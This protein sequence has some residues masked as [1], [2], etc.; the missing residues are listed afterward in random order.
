MTECYNKLGL[1]CSIDVLN[2]FYSNKTDKNIYYDNKTKDIKDEDRF[3]FI[4]NE[5]INYI[6]NIDNPS[7][8]YKFCSVDNENNNYFYCN[9]V[10]KHK[11]P[12]FYKNS[13]YIKCVPVMLLDNNKEN[14]LSD[15]NIIQDKTN[16]KTTVEYKLQNYDLSVFN[17]IN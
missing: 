6:D 1:K 14:I 16:K 13:L 5:N 3:R 10:L 9:C 17:K 12:L 2:D 8:Q 15:H 11:S 7:K 4:N